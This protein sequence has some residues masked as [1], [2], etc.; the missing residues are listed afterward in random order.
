MGMKTWLVLFLVF[1]LLAGCSRGNRSTTEVQQ[2]FANGSVRVLDIRLPSAS[3]G[4]QIWY[5]AIVPATAPQERLPVLWFLHGAGSDPES[6]AEQSDIVNLSVR[7]HL[8]VIVPNGELSY[9]TNAEHKRRERWED[10]LVQELSADVASR[11]PVLS[12]TDHTGIAGIS[13]GGYGAAKLALKHPERYG[14][15]GIMSGALDITRRPAS[16]AR[17]G[18]TWRIWTIFGFTRQAREGEDVFNLLDRSRSDPNLS[19]FVSCGSEDPLHSV[20]VRFAGKLRKRGFVA[21]MTSTSGG[22]DWRS[23]NQSMPA[24]FQAAARRLK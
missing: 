24:L 1:P 17:W 19:W 20:N 15:V 7:S 14:F 6:M 22:H 9:Y 10:V 4:R 5:R 2:V 12:G 8:I 11:F 16:L 3:L 18:Q 23:W 13:M 21:Q